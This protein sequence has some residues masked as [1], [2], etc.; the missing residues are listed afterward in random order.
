MTR[1]HDSDDPHVSLSNLLFFVS[2]FLISPKSKANQSFETLEPD[3]RQ[4]WNWPKPTDTHR[5]PPR[6]L[7]SIIRTTI[8]FWC[9]LPFILLFSLPIIVKGKTDILASFN[10]LVLFKTPLFANVR[11]SLFQ[12]PQKL[13]CRLSLHFPLCHELRQSSCLLLSS[14]FRR[15]SSN[16]TDISSPWSSCQCDPSTHQI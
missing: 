12:T 8:F 1:P 14:L 16:P 5:Y 10:P 2:V 9:Q 4:W 7:L 11:L 6:L 15:S 3:S 13:I